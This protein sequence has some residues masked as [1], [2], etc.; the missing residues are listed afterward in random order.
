MSR[1]AAPH[2]DPKGPGD[3]RPTALQIVQDEGFE[4]KLTGKVAV[5]T[6]VSSGLGIE[7]VKALAATGATL[8]LTA[9]NLAKAE[10][11]LAEI[12]DPSTMTLV[13][14]DQ[15]SLESVRIAAQTILSKTTQISLLVANAGVMAIPDLRLTDKGHEMQFATNHLSHFLFFN[16]LK[17]AL[18]TGSSSA[19]QSRVV[20]LSSAGHRIGGINSSDNYHYENGEYNPW[21]AYAQSKTANVYMANEIERRY[22]SQ[23]LHAYSLHPGISATG[24]IGQLTSE[25]VMGMLQNEAMLKAQK[26]LDQGAATTIYAAISKELE[27]R[28]GLYLNDCSEAAMGEQDGNPMSGKSA[29]HSFHP[30]NEARLWKD[31]LE[32][33][34][35][36]D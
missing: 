18:L 36:S 16:L 17:S 7:T 25:E 5:V 19:F 34:G 12:F 30:E 31:S 15:A 11:A 33:V 20:I 10:A 2:V 26:G 9:R 32:M 28:G 1:Y 22:A 24:I 4:G 29:P 3:A 35:L 23:G 27:G 6:G 21:A 8:F 13:Q 14:M